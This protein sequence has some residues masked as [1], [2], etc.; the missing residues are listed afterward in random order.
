M[1]NGPQGDVQAAFGLL[2][3]LELR[4]VRLVIHDNSSLADLIYLFNFARID[5]IRSSSSATIFPFSNI[6]PKWP[7]QKWSAR[8]CV[9]S[10]Y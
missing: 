10:N 8:T 1:S 6:A 5:L 7:S 4:L 2:H 3:C 9:V